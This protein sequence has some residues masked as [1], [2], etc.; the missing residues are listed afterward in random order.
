M[1][2]ILY[3]CNYVFCFRNLVIISKLMRNNLLRCFYFLYYQETVKG[4]CNLK[5]LN[6]QIAC[7]TVDILL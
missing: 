3:K 6:H 4:S 5:H 2:S 7:E 1:T